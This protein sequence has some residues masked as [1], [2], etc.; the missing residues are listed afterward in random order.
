MMRLSLKP[1]NERFL[2]GKNN[3][4]KD[5]EI[6]KPVIFIGVKALFK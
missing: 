1:L 4:Q 6:K 5:S 2:R 3:L